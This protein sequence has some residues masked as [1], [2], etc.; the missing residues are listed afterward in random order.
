MCEIVVFEKVSLYGFYMIVFG[1]G[2]VY[3]CWLIY[4]V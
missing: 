2:K 3:D 1:L 4:G